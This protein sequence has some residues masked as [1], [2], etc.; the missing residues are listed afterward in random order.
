MG[1]RGYDY[2]EFASDTWEDNYVRIVNTQICLR[3]CTDRLISLSFLLFRVSSKKRLIRLRNLS[4][5]FLQFYK[6]TNLCLICTSLVFI[7]FDV[8][9]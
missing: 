3:I 5:P 2:T 7:G 4:L 6:L 9:W 8:L 1:S